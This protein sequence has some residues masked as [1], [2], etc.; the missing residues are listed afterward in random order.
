VGTSGIHCTATHVVPPYGISAFQ[1]LGS[2][3]LRRGQVTLQGLVE[4][5][6][7]DDP[8]PFRVAITGGTGAYR[9]A[10]GEAVVF[11]PRPGKNIYKLRFDKKH[12]HRGG[13][14]RH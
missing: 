1:C 5:Q 4:I 9:G 8:G 11:E 2:L 7:M 13:H 10:S 12:R 6:G 3:S 14:H